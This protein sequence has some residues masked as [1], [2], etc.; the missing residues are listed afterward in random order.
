[1]GN[2]AST[3]DFHIRLQQALKAAGWEEHGGM[4]LARTMSVAAPTV[5]QWVYGKVVP[6]ADKAWKMAKL[7]GVPFGWLYF[8]EGTAAYSTGVRD[9]GHG[10]EL[11]EVPVFNARAA[12]GNGLQNHETRQIGSLLFRPRS[13]VKRQIPLATTR[14][15]YVHGDSMMPRLR[16]GDA[17]LFDTADNTPV[18]GKMFVVRWNELELIKRLRFE[19]CTWWLTSDNRSNPEWSQP[20]A[21]EIGH[22]CA[23]LGRVRWVGSWED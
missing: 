1:M 4:R 20:R 3:R 10:T 15:L 21:V 13:L 17:V 8:G 19:R 14:V 7:L 11:V 9:Q 18:D 22:D 23:I 12:A 2:S 6:T 16:D 5:S